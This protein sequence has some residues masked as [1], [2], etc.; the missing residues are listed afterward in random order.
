MGSH[1][2]GGVAKIQKKRRKLEKSY[3]DVFYTRLD[4][5]NVSHGF[6]ILCSHSQDNSQLLLS[7]EIG[8]FEGSEAQ[9]VN[10]SHQFQDESNHWKGR[11]QNTFPSISQSSVDRSGSYSTVSKYSTVL[12][13]CKVSAPS[14]QW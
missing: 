6:E 13:N 3:P 8:A 5:L 2:L 7:S 10:I 9:F 11:S 14:D 1:R 4:V 12:S